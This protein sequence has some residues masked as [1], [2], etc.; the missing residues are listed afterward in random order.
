MTAPMV[1]EWCT[2]YRRE[3]VETANQPGVQ[4]EVEMLAG[5]DP[6]IAALQGVATRLYNAWLDRWR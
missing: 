3:L 1:R 4:T 6:R 5:I 2:R